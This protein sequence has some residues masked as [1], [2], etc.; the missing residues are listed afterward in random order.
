MSGVYSEIQTTLSISDCRFVGIGA[1]S[2]WYLLA[3]TSHN[4]ISAA[5]C[6]ARSSPR[7]YHWLV[8]HHT[9]GKFI[10]DYCDHR[11][12]TIYAKII[13]ISFL[14]LTIGISVTLSDPLWLKFLLGGIAVAVTVHLLS[15]N[16]IRS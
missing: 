9:L 1:G 2:P 11:G 7:L 5:A 3:A 15:L 10:A 16:A 13:S 4:P 12:I 6:F 8:H 14:W